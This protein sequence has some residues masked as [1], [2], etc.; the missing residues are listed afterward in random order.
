MQIPLP[1][2]VLTG[3][4]LLGC[5]LLAVAIRL[6][7]RGAEGTLRQRVAECL[8]PRET[9]QREDYRANYFGLESLGGWQL[10]GNGALV[11]T[12]QALEFQMLWPRRRFRVSLAE[13]TGSALVRWHCGK[14]VGRDLL[15]VSFQAGDREDSVAWFVPNA[16]AWKATLDAEL[17]RSGAC[18]DDR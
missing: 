15:K 13:V 10:R 12:D 6:L 11:L 3:G 1:W 5:T 2:L 8:E 9:I 14:S 7:I 18:G 16:L 17:S 4:L